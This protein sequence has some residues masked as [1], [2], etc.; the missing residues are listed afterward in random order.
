MGFFHLPVKIA[1]QRSAISRL[2]HP[3]IE[4]NM[5]EKRPNEPVSIGIAE[6]NINALPACGTC[7]ALVVPHPRSIHEPPLEIRVCRA[8]VVIRECQTEDEP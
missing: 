4:E 3:F 8:R 5:H 2:A 6:Y 7:F 1:I